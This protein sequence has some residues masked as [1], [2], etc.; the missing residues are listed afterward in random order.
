MKLAKYI[1]FKLCLFQTRKSHISLTHYTL[2]VRTQIYFYPATFEVPVPSQ[3]SDQLC[4]FVLSGVDF[5][6][7]YDFSLGF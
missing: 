4:I 7:F 5:A 2:K 6:S 3:D 1:L